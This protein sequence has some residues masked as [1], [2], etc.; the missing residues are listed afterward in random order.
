V[1]VEHDVVGPLIAHLD[2]ESARVVDDDVA[3]IERGVGLR[4]LPFHEIIRYQSDM[5]LAVRRVAGIRR[6]LGLVLPQADH[7]DVAFATVHVGIRQRRHVVDGRRDFGMRAHPPREREVR[8]RV[9]TRR[10]RESVAEHVGTLRKILDDREV[11]ARPDHHRA[12]DVALLTKGRRADVRH[13][14]IRHERRR[15]GNDRRGG[16]RAMLKNDIGC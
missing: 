6:V 10:D 7:D 2:R 5:R 11:V 1:H 8:E 13:D 12:V 9:E 3:E 4:R 15:F 14:A 16:V